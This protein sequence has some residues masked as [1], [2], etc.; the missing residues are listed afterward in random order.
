MKNIYF[1]LALLFIAINNNATEKFNSPQTGN[2]IIP[3][4]FADP[5]LKK[6]GDTY[7]L[8]A[9]TDGNGAGFGPSQVWCSKDFI[10]WTIMPMNWPT[11]H[12]IWAP[13]VIKNSK[14]E[15]FFI[16]SQP[17]NLYCGKSNTPRGPWK[18]ILGK[19]DAIFVPDRYVENS[20]TLDGQTFI[21]DDGSIYMYWGTWGIYEGF[22]C[23]AVQLSEDMEILNK[24][25]IPNTELTD[26][27]EAPYMIKRNG[28]YYL[29]YSSGSCHDETY[30]VQYA[31][32]TESPFGPFTYKG[33]I[34]E[35]S[36]DKTI[37]G[38]G[39]HSVFY[40]EENDK[41]YIVYH[42]HNIPNST[43][44]FHRQISV[45]E[46]LFN[47]KNE[48]EK[49]KPTHK[50]VL[51]QFKSNLTSPNIANGKKVKSSSYY[52][53]N[54]LP[55]YAVDDNNATLWKPKTTEYE[56]IT[57]DLESEQEIRSV[58]TQF[59]YGTF[60]YQYLIETSTDGKEWE[61]FSDKRNNYLA[62]SPMV[63]FG[64]A[65]ARFLRITNTGHQKN[66]FFGAIWNIKV[67]NSYETYNPQRWIGI[68]GSDWD[69]KSWNNNGGMLG[70]K[71]HIEKG[72]V[73]KQR[74][75]NE[76]VIKLNP[77]TILS[78]ESSLIT[79]KNC[80]FSFWQ[81]KKGEWT[82][83]NSKSH[84]SKGKIT[85]K[86]ENEPIIIT[87]L[88]YYN[89]QL[90]PEEEAFDAITPIQKVEASTS[91]KQG[92]TIHIDANKFNEG[93]TIHY[94][95]NQG[96]KGAFIY[97]ESP[98]LVQYIQGKKAFHFTGTQWYES[99]FS[100]PYSLIDNAPYTLEA[101]VLNPEMD[102]NECII[103]FTSTHNELEKIML[104]NGT[105]PRCGIL[106][107]YGWYED[108]GYSNAKEFENK[109]QHIYITF[110]GRMEEVYINDLLIS[111]KD[112]QLLLKKSQKVTIGKN[113]E[114]NW[115]FKGYI[116]NIKLYDY[117]IPYSKKQPINI[118]H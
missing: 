73:E 86:S 84:I 81:Y 67:F 30:R 89:W 71:F 79:P 22:G 87:N 43:R 33:C 7:Y 88:R 21:D 77:N 1:I 54:F 6:Y 27:F 95:P 47:D 25:L 56:W 16:Y 19:E 28:I 91:T 45:D 18:N 23:G 116:H 34:L 5:T 110:D 108:V 78:Y 109:W 82:Y 83:Q 64:K 117:Y 102:E 115:P 62:G 53:E 92:L 24:K 10:N 74:I 69:G 37:H 75:N 68:T 105:E 94:I 55:Q 31:T 76:E 46:L 50:G 113:A 44:G 32:S 99:N 26:F 15:Y 80:T 38:P 58:W 106:N 93:D 49:I 11:T 41:Y 103:D 60:F 48:I 70:G 4:Y 100:L 51:N 2:P 98:C 17:C 3:G 20:I 63:D 114:G 65:K 118:K 8:Y 9:T 13:D 72:L 111:K 40:E 35:T 101:Y 97:K 59:E 14:D 52:D 107:H 29:M 36:E 61:I 112:I 57:I 12:W 104:V 66:G 85:L 39:H 96:L 42:R 90:S